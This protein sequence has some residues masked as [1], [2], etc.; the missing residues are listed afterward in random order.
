MENMTLNMLR[1]I[2]YMTQKLKQAWKGQRKE[3]E[4]EGIPN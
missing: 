1:P 2:N 4:K 3:M